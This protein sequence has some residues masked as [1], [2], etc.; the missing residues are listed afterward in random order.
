MI[1]KNVDAVVL[2]ET[3]TFLAMR[4]NGGYRIASQIRS[5]GY[6]CQ[7]FTYLKYFSFNKFRKYLSTAIGPD[8]KL[9]C[10]SAN[11]I[12][13]Q[14]NFYMPGSLTGDDLPGDPQ[15]YKQAR[16]QFYI[17]VIDYV[18][19]LNPNIKVVIGGNQIAFFDN[20]DTVDVI[21][22]GHGDKAIVELLRF[23]GNKNPFLQFTQENNKMV[24]DGD[25]LNKRFDFQS[26][27]TI[28]HPTDYLHANEPLI[29]EVGRSCNHRHVDKFG[30]SYIKHFESLREELLRNYYKH[31]TTNYIVSDNTLNDNTFKLK[32][33]AKLA[34]SLPFQFRFSAYLRIDLMSEHK[35]QYQ[36][37]KDAGLRGA[38]FS[39]ETLNHNA[40][41]AI[42]K[43][44]HPDKVIEE[45]HQFRDQ[46]PEVATWGSF[47]IG[48]PGDTKK[49]VTTWTSTIAD[50]EFPLDTISLH[51]LNVAPHSIVSKTYGDDSSGGLSEFAKN[52]EK[53]FTFNDEQDPLN[54]HNGS[55]DKLWTNQ[56]VKEF[57]KQLFAN[58]RQSIGGIYAIALPMLGVPIESAKKKWF[59]LNI[60]V[61]R[62][63][64]AR[65]RMSY[66]EKLLEE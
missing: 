43:K 41:K 5:A 48:L 42:G 37:L 15:E 19:S 4:S 33:M 52:S 56:F 58:N 39:I 7:N 47:I 62:S 65:L 50:P 32:Q 40:G 26:S 64:R 44:L 30:D 28:Y 12:T 2:T 8:T 36:L 38:Q 1:Q 11:F 13:E 9:L 63:V 51:P 34:Q 60:D 25:S 31:G 54:W 49:T 6:S 35:E 16:K 45:L 29:I 24:I 27:Q 59:D 53:Y 23:L 17:Q 66:A 20:V 22:K 61:N 21:V 10:I 3:V 55:F 14:Q 46:L 18:K 57:H